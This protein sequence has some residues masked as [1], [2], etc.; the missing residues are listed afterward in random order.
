MDK[1]YTVHIESH[2]QKKIK[3]NLSLA[4]LWILV[5][6]TPVKLYFTTL[7]FQ[8]TTNSQLSEYQFVRIGSSET[9]LFPL[10]HL[11]RLIYGI[12]C[13]LLYLKIFRNKCH[14]WNMGA[15]PTLSTVFV[16]AATLPSPCR[17]A[18]RSEQSACCLHALHFV[19]SHAWDGS[20]MWVAIWYRR[21]WD[22]L[23]P[24][25]FGSIRF[26][27]H[28]T[29]LLHRES[30]RETDRDRERPLR[31]GGGEMAVELTRD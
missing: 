17:P 24:L 22:W 10:I 13:L 23:G 25:L 26:M 8:I 3:R 12:T 19:L 4:T 29:V 20:S 9:L 28:I 11:V 14:F 15:A 1:G 16:L 2:T 7:L 30:A 6:I 5:P 18:Y 21:G 27:K 31:L